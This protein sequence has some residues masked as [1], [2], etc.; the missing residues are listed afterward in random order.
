[1]QHTLSCVRPA[2]E[3]NIMTTAQTTYPELLLAPR[4]RLR[5]EAAKPGLLSR[6]RTLFARSGD[7]FE[8]YDDYF[9]EMERSLPMHVREQRR[10]RRQADRMLLLASLSR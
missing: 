6:L 7:C 3:T 9:A 5:Q 4:G 1:M 10:E 8:S 2:K